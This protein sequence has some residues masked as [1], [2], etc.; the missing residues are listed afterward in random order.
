MPFETAVCIPTPVNFRYR[1]PILGNVAKSYG[2]ADKL[3]PNNSQKWKE[4][5]NHTDQ[6][7]FESVAGDLLDR[8]GYE[9]QGLKKELSSTE[10]L[11]YRLRELWGQAFMHLSNNQKHKWLW[12]EL[13]MRWI[14]KRATLKK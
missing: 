3:V 10:V 13:Q 9:I 1:K 6:V 4:E 7:V 12:T 11:G 5:M 2:T 8:L 14:T